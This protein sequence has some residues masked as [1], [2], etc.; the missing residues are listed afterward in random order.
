MSGLSVCAAA[1]DALPLLLCGE[2]ACFPDPWG[3]G[4]IR[5]QLASPVGLSLLCHVDGE[6]AGYLFASLLPPEGEI[7]RIATF[8]AFRRRGVGRAL[9]SE[10]FRRAEAAGVDRLFLDVR[11]SNLPARALYAAGGFCEYGRR[12]AYYRAPREDAILM[13]RK[14]DENDALSGL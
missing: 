1:E 9:L 6:A 11:E 12:S 4:G 13:E 7:L 5:G 2:R 3:E 14:S 10:F 8:P